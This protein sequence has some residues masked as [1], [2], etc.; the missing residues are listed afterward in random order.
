MTSPTADLGRVICGWCPTILADDY[1]TWYLHFATVH[2][3]NG[4]SIK[5]C[6]GMDWD[7]TELSPNESTP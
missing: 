5:P 1:T 7:I 3:T 6:K 2:G 4:Y